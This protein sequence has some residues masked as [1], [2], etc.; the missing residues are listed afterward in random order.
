[1]D[2]GQ[3][4]TIIFG[5]AGFMAIFMFLINRQID[6]LSKRIDSIEKRIDD[7]REDV[8]RRFDKLEQD[9]REIRQ[10]LYKVLGTEVKRDSRAT[11]ILYPSQAV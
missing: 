1:M 6:M 9:V 3:V 2:W 11:P 4:I 10:L 5:V 7:L 8:N